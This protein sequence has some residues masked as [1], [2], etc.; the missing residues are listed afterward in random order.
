MRRCIF[1][2]LDCDRCKNKNIDESLYCKKHHTIIEKSNIESREILKNIF[3]DNRLNLYDIYKRNIDKPLGRSEFISILH[4]VL[5]KRDY[6]YIN[7]IYN[8]N[9]KTIPGIANAYYKLCITTNK[10]SEKTEN[11]K[12]INIIKRRWKKYIK[13]S[14]NKS[15]NKEDPFTFDTIEEIPLKLRFKYTDDDNHKYIFNA[16]EF[17]YFLRNNGKWNPYN[18]K[19]ISENI[20]TILDEFI[21]KNNL[22]RKTADFNWATH[23]QA[24]TDVSQIMEKNGFYNDIKWFEKINYSMCSKIINIYRDISPGSEYFN[25]DYKLSKTDFVFDF[26]KEVIRMFKNGEEHYLL[27]C[28]LFKALALNIEE[29][30]NNIPSWLY[31]VESFSNLIPRNR[32]YYTYMYEIEGQEELYNILNTFNILTN[33]MN[34]N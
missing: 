10:I 1:R 31:N 34:I 11:I 5:N 12:K 13:E 14:I 29:F 6:A 2:K 22:K 30:Y 21:K 32:L 25:I 9:K 19:P 18:K 28:N 26:C 8:L 33:D 20:V 16:L 17:E 15:E 4:I 7:D 27:C 23:T 3:E 24:Y